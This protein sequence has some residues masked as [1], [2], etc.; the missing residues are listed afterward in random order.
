MGVFFNQESNVF[1]LQTIHSTYQMKVGETGELLHLY[2]GS[3]ISE[4]DLSYLLFDGENHFVPYPYNN[5]ERTGSLDILPQEFPTIGKGDS[6]SAAL[7]IV[8]ADGTSIIDLKFI[9]FEI[10]N[11]KH[12][13]E[14]LPSFYQNSTDKVQTLFV[15]LLDEISNIEVELY[16]GVFEEYDVITRSAKI[17]NYGDKSIDIR[18]IQSIVLD[19]IDGDYSLTHFH[20]KWAM[21][22]QIEEINVS[23]SKTS[24]GSNYGVSGNKQN[25]GFIL[26]EKGSSEFLGNCY[27]FNLVY[28]GNFEATVEKAS[29]GQIR[30]SLGMG[31]SSFCWKLNSGEIFESPE[32]IM[33]FSDQGKS[34][35]SHNFHNL[36]RNNLC[37]SKFS[38]KKRPVLINNWEATYFDF[39]GKKIIEIAEESKKIG[40]DLIVMDDGWF[41]NRIDDNRALGD[42]KPNEGKL[43]MSLSQLIESVNNC[44]LDFGIWMEPEM[45]SEDS[46][47]YHRHPEWVLKYPNRKPQLGRNQ[48]VLDLTNK[49]VVEY[50]YHKVSNILNSGPI[51]YLKWDM[52]RPISDWYSSRLET[53]TQGELQHRYLLGLY[54][55][56]R[57][58]TEEH[59]TVL[60]EGCASG[61]ARFDLGMLAFHPQIWT[62]DNTDPIN[63]LKIQYGTSYMYPISAMGAHVSASPNHQNGRI[64]PFSTRAYVAMAGTFGYELDVT[65]MTVDEK[66]EVKEYTKIYKKI[67]GLTFTGDYFRLKEDTNLTVWQ[68]VSKNKRESV[69][70]YVYKQNEGNPNFGYVRLKGLKPDK[71]YVIGNQSL[72]GNVLM[73][74]G[75][76][77]EQPKSNYTSGQ[78]FVKIK[79]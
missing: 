1:T 72:Y 4:S 62:S 64:T 3:K 43:G 31:D 28:S 20:G 54:D 17:K 37:L 24:F 75:L 9:D 69:I 39:D 70:T 5:S 42:W 18:K 2:Y 22:R 49:D 33:S 68:I 34:K 32:G 77:L 59:P 27:G 12:Q 46:D 66:R 58:L 55:L 25:P 26:S 15:T 36:I 61:G 8:N 48:L 16:Y 44:G 35:L 67:Q 60:F 50:I 6:R 45:V 65:K 29:L 63:R 78:I 53:G 14:S 47:L 57:R 30:V 41:G 73:N 76:K 21:E 79:K 51:T 71:V 23:H 19:F 7:D 52:N 56:L 13:L 38:K 10:I 74:V 11:G 40:V